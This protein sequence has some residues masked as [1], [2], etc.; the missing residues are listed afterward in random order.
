MAAAYD[1]IYATMVAMET[2]QKSCGNAYMC[3]ISCQSNGGM[4]SHSPPPPPRLSL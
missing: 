1:V 4:T 2:R 3:Q